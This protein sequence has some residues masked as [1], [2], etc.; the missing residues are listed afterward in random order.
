[1]ELL[2]KSSSISGANG[3][4]GLAE[5]FI[6]R[7]SATKRLNDKQLA[8]GYI[9]L[10]LKYMMYGALSSY[11]AMEPLSSYSINELFVMMHGRGLS[12]PNELRGT[13]SNIVR[14]ECPSTIKN[15]VSITTIRSAYNK[16]NALVQTYKLPSDD[17]W[18]D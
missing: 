12:I 8:A 18:A 4:L 1:M 17:F 10:A 2:V 11:R 6:T 9:C 7:Y 16:L 5:S 15:S 14:W 3:A 13:F